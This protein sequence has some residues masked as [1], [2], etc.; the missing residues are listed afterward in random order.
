MIEWIFWVYIAL[1][2]AGLAVLLMMMIFGGLDF[3]FGG[4]DIEMGGVDFDVGDMDAGGGVGLPLILSFVSAFGWFGAI[5][6]YMKIHIVL[7]PI[8]SIIAALGISLI[9][10][11][12][13]RYFLKHFSSD[14]TVKFRS[15]IGKKGSVSVP[16]RPGEEGQIVVFTDQ[17]GRTII[18][19]VSDKRI[20]NNAEVVIV[21]IIGDAVKVMS[22]REFDLQ[23]RKRGKDRS[24][25]KDK[26]RG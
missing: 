21:G 15:L 11:L 16:I 22:K 12:L 18:P 10:F 13:T 25:L 2:I 8:I 3:G 5:L 26:N 9:L 23:K 4:V 14:S 6:T 17:R 1:G 19:A 20:L 24:D 7:T